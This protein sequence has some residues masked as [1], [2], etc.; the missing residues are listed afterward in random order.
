MDDKDRMEILHQDDYY[1]VV[2]CVFGSLFIFLVFVTLPSSINWLSISMFILGLAAFFLQHVHVIDRNEL[3]VTTYFAI[4]IQ[5]KRLWIRT[6]FRWRTH[7]IMGTKSIVVRQGE[8]P[9]LSL[10]GEVGLGEKA[11]EIMIEYG[12]ERIK[13][14]SIQSFESARKSANEI[15]VFLGLS[16]VELNDFP[17]ASEAYYKGEYINEMFNQLRT[18]EAAGERLEAVWALLN[19]IDSRPHALASII[20]ALEDENEEVRYAAVMVLGQSEE[21]EASRFLLPLL[22]DDS[23]RVREA[24]AR[25]LGGL[26][27]GNKAD[28]HK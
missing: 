17:P 24:V 25:F 22:N 23:V 8:R 13:L 19:Y 27:G 12:V 10:N 26:S 2:R 1:F 6:P 9:Y 20:R 4:G 16:Q 21:K 28:V 11:H 15:K 3:T 18:A 14:M 5:H 7:S